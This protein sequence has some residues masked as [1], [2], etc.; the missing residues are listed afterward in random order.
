ML[1]FLVVTA[2]V[3]IAAN[4]IDV[5]HKGRVVTVDDNAVGAHLRHGD[6]LPTDEVC[7][8]G[9]D[10]D[11]DG[12]DLPCE[13]GTCAD[14]SGAVH[15]WPADGTAEDIVG[16][17]DGGL[18]GAVYESA[19]VDLGFSFAGGNDV[20]YI[21][22]APAFVEGDSL[23]V[24]LWLYL[25]DRCDHGNRDVLQLG[26]LLEIRTDSSAEHCGRIAAWFSKDGTGNDNPGV[27]SLYWFP[28]EVGAWH[29][30]AATFA[31]AGTGTFSLYLDGALAGSVNAASLGGNFSGC[32]QSAE[33]WFG[34]QCDPALASMQGQL[35][36]LA[37]H[38]RVLTAEEIAAISLAGPHGRCEL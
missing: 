5:C 2:S 29:H 11:C 17:L 26:R 34:G 38:N 9:V 19:L 28:I 20:V 24:E 1:S 10:Q 18:Y 12:A 7:G 32:V 25:D 21:P 33:T 23:T 8:D 6:A 16:G 15:Y 36:E 30:V 4:P 14:V 35:D 31:G 37:V 3:A 13:P 27:H 22:G